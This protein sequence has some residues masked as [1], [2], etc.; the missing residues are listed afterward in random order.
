MRC[1]AQYVYDVRGQEG[2][3]RGVK[4]QEEEMCGVEGFEG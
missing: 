4:S 2:D 1:R 3:V